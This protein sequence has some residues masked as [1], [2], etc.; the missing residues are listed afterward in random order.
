MLAFFMI[1][2]RHFV[3]PNGEHM[4]T[5]AFIS[6]QYAINTNWYGVD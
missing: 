4:K 3:I 5:Q 2:K 6:T 1:G